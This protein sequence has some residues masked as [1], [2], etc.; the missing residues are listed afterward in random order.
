C[1][2]GSPGDVQGFAAAESSLEDGAGQAL[3]NSLRSGGG[4]AGIEGV[5]VARDVDVIPALQGLLCWWNCP[6]SR[7]FPALALASSVTT[8]CGCT[9]PVTR[10]VS[11]YGRS[12]HT[13]LAAI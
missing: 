6:A 2:K 8:A 13:P 4:P 11:T 1:R 10:V 3:Q 12:P 7:S 9:G 5:A